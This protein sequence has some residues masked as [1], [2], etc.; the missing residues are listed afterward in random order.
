MCP[1]DRE[2]SVGDP[3]FYFEGLFKSLPGVVQVAGVSL[4]ICVSAK[5]IIFGRAVSR[6]LFIYLFLLAISVTSNK[7]V[8]TAY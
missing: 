6:C 3:G 5:N 4:S 7:D 8:L 2:V 1:M